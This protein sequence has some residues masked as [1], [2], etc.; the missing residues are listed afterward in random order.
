[1]SEAGAE[2]HDVARA[3]TLLRV[4]RGWTQDD[5]AKASRVSPSAISAYERGHK[6]PG[7]AILGRL[8]R[9]MEFPLSAIDHTRNYITSLM[10]GT[11]VLAPPAV[12]SP[13]VP[14][15]SSSAVAR[16]IDQAAAEFG[17]A[18]AQSMRIALHVVAR[19]PA[20][21]VPNNGEPS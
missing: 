1:M 21:D 15:T 16:E 19:R 14:P 6:I 20:P 12:A 2:R 10:A 18:A 4:V 17:R 7:L 13:F 5:L 11:F 3:I 9:A 8:I